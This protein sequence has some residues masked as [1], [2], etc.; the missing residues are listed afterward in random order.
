[1]DV[2]GNPFIVWADGRNGNLDIYYTG[3]SYLNDP[4]HTDSLVYGDSLIIKTS[5]NTQISI[6]MSAFP[7]GFAVSDITISRL[8]NPPRLPSD[9]FGDC[10]NFGPGGLQFSYYATITIPHA[11]DVPDYGEY[12]AYWYDT[13]TGTWSQEGITDVQ[14][15]ALSETVHTVTFRT[16]HLTSF[17]IGGSA[18]SGGSSDDSSVTSGGCA[19][20]PYPGNKHSAGGFFLPFI[21]YVLILLKMTHSIKHKQKAKNNR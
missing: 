18:S 10:Y 20:S 17:I 8:S 15:H 5:N 16:M 9:A 3:T 12:H 4:M 2:N 11:A 14:H 13:E 6:P 1:M 19:M 7:N 21:V